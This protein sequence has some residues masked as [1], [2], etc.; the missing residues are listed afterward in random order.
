MAAASTDRKRLVRIDRLVQAYNLPR[1]RDPDSPPPRFAPECS[2][3][4]RH[5]QKWHEKRL[6][7]PWP[8]RQYIAE[9][10]GANTSPSPHARLPSMPGS[11]PSSRR[12]LAAR[13]ATSPE[14]SDAALNQSQVALRKNKTKTDHH[15]SPSPPTCRWRGASTTPPPATAAPLPPSRGGSY[16][17]E[18]HAWCLELHAKPLRITPDT[19][20]RILLNHSY[21][22]WR[23]WTLLPV[24]RVDACVSMA[25]AFCQ[26]FSLSY[27]LLNREKVVEIVKGSDAET[28][29]AL[30]MQKAARSFLKYLQRERLR[31]QAAAIAVISTTWCIKLFYRA[32]RHRRRRAHDERLAW[33]ADQL[34]GLRANWSQVTAEPHM[35]VQLLSADF[36]IKTRQCE[37]Q[38]QLRCHV[39]CP[40][41]IGYFV[42]H[43]LPLSQL[44]LYD[45]HILKRLQNRIAGR[46]GYVFSTVPSQADLQVAHTLQLPLLSSLAEETASLRSWPALRA[47][48]DLGSMLAPVW[49]LTA[50]TLK[51]QLHS[52]AAGIV[53][54]AVQQ[55][56]DRPGP[57][58]VAWC[59]T[60][61]QSTAID[62]VRILLP[63]TCV[64]A[65]LERIVGAACDYGPVWHADAKLRGPHERR[66]ANELPDLL[67]RFAE[68]PNRPTLEHAQAAAAPIERL[69]RQLLE[70][71]A[72]VRPEFE[73][74][75]L[76]RY[77]TAALLLPNQTLARTGRLL[78][79]TTGLGCLEPGPATVVA[80][81]DRVL[82]RLRERGI[83]GPVQLRWALPDPGQAPM[84]EV[85]IQRLAPLVLSGAPT[86]CLVAMDIR[87]TALQACSIQSL[88][89]MLRALEQEAQAIG[90]KPMRARERQHIGLVLAQPAAACRTL[91]ER[92]LALVVADKV[93]PHP[94]DTLP[95]I[96]NGLA[97]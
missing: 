86:P 78:G 24:A 23:E 44:V 82:T 59:L 4:Q 1:K 17:E 77:E 65:H 40:E 73:V 18:Q 38:A 31:R 53:Q 28:Q 75:D 6:Q 30:V 5:L 34:E 89:H 57:R 43:N 70:T 37:S 61:L 56:Q 90:I 16:R 80:A 68:C 55:A 12:T 63:D 8:N 76:P 71:G 54:H 35:I 3:G 52:L 97:L 81:S 92:L 69:W 26:L 93:P 83:L 58:P 95:S 7:D 74:K 15:K 2:P 91:L 14:P 11:L 42:A 48:P 94:N 25:D 9:E 49:Q 60:T 29:A 66:L 88:R 50:G 67:D 96:L 32:M 36:G 46:P 13:Q 79:Q 41:S 51:R 62:N 64:R 19:A 27:V 20:A 39:L 45:G 85:A 87:H 21:R 10:F 72:I 22:Q 84:L 33:N 47:D